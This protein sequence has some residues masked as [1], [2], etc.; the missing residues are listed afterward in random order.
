MPTRRSVLSTLTAI[1]VA[2]GAEPALADAA[3]TAGEFIDRLMRDLTAVVNAPGSRE[4]KRA[5]L[6]KIVDTSV[7][8]PEVARFCLGRFWRTASPPQQ[9]EYLE[10]FHR[11]LVNS[12]TEK[13]G[14]YKGVTYTIG[15]AMPRDDAVDVPTVVTRPGNAANRVEWMVSAASGRPKIV[16]IIAE[17]VSM[18]LTQRS[19]YAAYLQRNNNNVQSLIDA[20]RRQA[21]N[22]QG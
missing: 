11:V 20:M 5:T 15:R 7:D 13:V 4:E 19:D 17:G 22:P 18:R 12:V 2:G 10:L 8:M 9:H 16:D 1:A 21:N 14:E 6:E 3:S